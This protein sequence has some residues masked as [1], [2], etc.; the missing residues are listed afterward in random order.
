[1]LKTSARLLR[2]LSLLL[3]QRFWTGAELTSRLEVT[4]RTLR[5]DI[6]RL[7]RLGY[8]VDG[9][10]GVA[11]GYRL[12]AGTRLP[13]LTLAE[14]E[15]LAISIALRTAGSHLSTTV[16]EAALRALTKLEHVFPAR[17]RHRANVLRETITLL[18][19]PGPRVDSDLLSLLAVACDERRI[20]AFDYTARNEQRTERVVE[21]VGLV[22]TGRWYFVAFDRGRD[23]WRTFRVDRI[24]GPRFA[25]GHFTPRP[26]PADGDLRAF[27]SRSIAVFAYPH[28]AD[29]LLHA[30]ADEVAARVSPTAAVLERLDSGRCRLS[31]GAHS[32]FSLAL[33]TASLGV[34][35]E[36]I[37]P[38]ELLDAIRELRE[39]FDRVL[40]CSK[41]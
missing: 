24:S 33:W 4:D 9:Q 38:P 15:A 14:D 18:E 29:I 22:H 35:F 10:P 13:P 30:S 5:R 27:V 3:S 6:D 12:Q 8:S 40:G 26:P 32:L 34:D 41:A 23:D 37:G 36:V 16:G 28:R 20:V 2:L 17:L 39:R 31:L 11:G 21:P 19:R 1:M 25:V 7:R